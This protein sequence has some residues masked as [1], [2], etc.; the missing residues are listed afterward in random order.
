MRYTD[1]ND[2]AIHFGEA[3]LRQIAGRIAILQ[4]EYDNMEG[5]P[6]PLGGLAKRHRGLTTD[7]RR[8]AILDERKEEIG[9]EMDA[10]RGLLSVVTDLR[11][12]LDKREEWDETF[13]LSMASAN[14]SEISRYTGSKSFLLD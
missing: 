1:S 3:K 6:F 9:A 2:K 8:Q 11:T 7:E 4:D 5:V 13:F 12:C 10:Y 14:R